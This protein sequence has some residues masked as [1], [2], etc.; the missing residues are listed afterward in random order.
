MD[1]R[2]ASKCVCL[3]NVLTAKV[4]AN[5]VFAHCVHR[6]CAIIYTVRTFVYIFTSE[7]CSWS[8]SLIEASCVQC[9]F[10]EGSFIVVC[11]IEGCPVL[12]FL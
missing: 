5:G 11:F 2:K 1:V 6:R 4:A 7:P 9:S 10:I 12:Y 3:E 8:I